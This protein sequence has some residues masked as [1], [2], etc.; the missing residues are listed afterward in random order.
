MKLLVVGGGGR[1]HAIADKLRRD[2]P[3]G[4]I[5]AAPGNPGTEAV[6]ASVP[7]DTHNLESLATFAAE[8]SLKERRAVQLSELL[9]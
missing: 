2:L 9:D 5:F 6:A 3:N 4:T 8:R 7:V 1:E